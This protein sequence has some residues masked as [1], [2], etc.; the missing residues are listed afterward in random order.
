MTSSSG[1]KR[2]APEYN[3]SGAAK[4]RQTTEAGYNSMF[5]GDDEELD[6]IAHDDF[7]EHFAIS[8]PDDNNGWTQSTNIRDCLNGRTPTNST[9]NKASGTASS[10]PK[11]TT[12]ATPPKK[13]M[14]TL[15]S[16]I[17]EDPDKPIVPSYLSDTNEVNRIKI[18]IGKRQRQIFA[19]REE[20]AKSPILTSFIVDDAQQGAFIMRPQL[21]NTNPADFDA[22]LQ[23][24]HTSTFEPLV[25][26]KEGDKRFEKAYS[27]DDYGKELIRLGKIYVIAQMFQVQGLEDAIYD[28]VCTISARRFPNKALVELAGVIFSDKRNTGGSAAGVTSASSSQTAAGEGQDD[29]AVKDK[30][31]EWIITKVA[32]NLQEIQKHQHEDFWAVEK[33]TTK[34]MFYARVLELAAEIYRANSG[35]L[36]SATVVEL[37]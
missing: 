14:S 32:S 12:K 3:D 6:E 15:N 24:I 5:V 35:R 9:A 25:V 16:E 13:K 19:Q 7:A 33:K 29:T 36:L 1:R 28:K 21:L 17:K 10:S 26:G 22:V 23:F 4:R 30:F 27:N 34:K 2:P 18:Y 11:T 20:I 31:E 37:D 8:E